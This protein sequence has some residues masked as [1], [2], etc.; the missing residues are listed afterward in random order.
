MQ[1][2]A[3]QAI[4]CAAVGIADPDGVCQYVGEN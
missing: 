4:Y 2:I 3:I 1:T